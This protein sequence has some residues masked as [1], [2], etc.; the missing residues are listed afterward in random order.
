MRVEYYSDKGGYN[1]T[2]RKAGYRSHNEDTILIESLRTADDTQYL[3]AVVCDGMGGGVDGKFSS[4]KVCEDIRLALED[5]TIPETDPLKA[6]QNTVYRA[7]IK[8]H[9]Y[10]YNK[11]LNQKQSATTCTALITDGVSYRYVHIGDT[12]LYALGDKLNLVTVDD[13]WVQREISR[14]N[15]TEAE[16]KVHRNRHMIT[17]AVGVGKVIQLY[18]S[19]EFPVTSDFLLTSDGFSEFLTQDKANILKNQEGELEH[20]AKLMINEGQKD[21][22]SAIIVRKD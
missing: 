21:N 12:R 7:V 10:I 6:I 8:A 4:S 1:G 5:M 19:N 14:G 3:V 11:Y 17:K 22:I 13:T 2:T 18:I 9:S 15:L 16:A 20:M